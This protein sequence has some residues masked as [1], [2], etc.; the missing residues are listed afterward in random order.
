MEQLI[1]GVDRSD[2]IIGLLRNIEDRMAKA[3]RKRTTNVRIVA[4]YLLLRTN[5]GGRT[6]CIE[7]CVKLGVDPDGYTFY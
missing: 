6:S 5:V 3:K 2:F 4:D 1:E 7:Q